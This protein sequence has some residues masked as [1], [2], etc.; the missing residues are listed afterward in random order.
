MNRLLVR[1]YGSDLTVKLD[2]SERHAVLK[3]SGLSRQSDVAVVLTNII[4]RSKDSQYGLVKDMPVAFMLFMKKISNG[5]SSVLLQL[6]HGVRS[7]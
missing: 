3:V 2:I 1:W 5:L 7:L 6:S 4:R